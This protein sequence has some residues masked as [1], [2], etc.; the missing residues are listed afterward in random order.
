MST[1]IDVENRQVLPTVDFS[2]VQ[3]RIFEEIFGYP[4][5]EWRKECGFLDK[6]HEK[7]QAGALC[8]YSALL[9]TSIMENDPLSLK[10][11]YVNPEKVERRKDE[12]RRRGKND[13]DFEEIL[14]TDVENCISHGLFK[15]NYNTDDK[16]NTEVEFILHPNRS[17]INEPIKISSKSIFLSLL[18]HFEKEGEDTNNGYG[19]NRAGD[20]KN[21]TIP[22]LLCDIANYYLHDGK[23]PEISGDMRPFV[24]FALRAGSLAYEQSDYHQIFRETRTDTT[25]LFENLSHMRN[26][27]RHYS[28]VFGD[29]QDF[30]S[31]ITLVGVPQN[32]ISALETPNAVEKSSSIDID[33]QLLSSLQDK[34][35]KCKITYL[36]YNRK[37]PNPQTVW[38]LTE[39][40]YESNLKM[41]FMDTAKIIA[42]LTQQE[43]NDRA[44]NKFRAFVKEGIKNVFYEQIGN[45]NF[46]G[47]KDI[48]DILD[49]QLKSYFDV[50]YLGLQPDS[51]PDS[52]SQ[53]DSN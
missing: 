29:D 46:D 20:L 31:N 34:N 36:D 10:P 22:C 14:K 23:K 1:W 47:E 48:I 19:D 9:F 30:S 43:K 41:Y 45:E 6:E 51:K 4:E 16:N 2:L 18:N 8:L 27:I 12:L 24:E 44:W 21:F 32:I 13:S 5:F 15:L 53:P 17:D 35:A 3:Y 38:Q 26:S 28:F 37:N 42:L 33:T 11:E 50:N 52:N 25:E 40:I 49:R 7:M 39:T